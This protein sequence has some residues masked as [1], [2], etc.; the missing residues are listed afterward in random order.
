MK[1]LEDRKYK[2]ERMQHTKGYDLDLPKCLKSEYFVREIKRSQKESSLYFDS[3]VFPLM[4]DYWQAVI[5]V[6]FLNRLKTIN[7]QAIF[8]KLINSDES[9]QL[10]VLQNIVAIARYG[11]FLS[12]RQKYPYIKMIPNQEIDLVLHAHIADTYQFRL[13]SQNLFGTDLNHMT[14]VGKGGEVERQKWLQNFSYTHKIFEQNFGS[15][16]MG[17]DVA[18]CCEI[19]LDFA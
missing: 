7:W 12:L 10:S 13:D 8:Q 4:L 17:S 18:A 11:L 19:L 14:E 9:Q 6:N 2:A 1:K 3:G 15:G 16:A 5:D